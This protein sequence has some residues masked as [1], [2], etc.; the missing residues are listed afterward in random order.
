VNEDNS[1]R[2]FVKPNESEPQRELFE[3]PSAPVNQSGT[4]AKDPAALGNAGSGIEELALADGKI[5]KLNFGFGKNGEKFY[6]VGG[7]KY[8]TKQRVLRALHELQE[9]VAD[10]FAPTLLQPNRPR[11]RGKL[12]T[13]SRAQ[14]EEKRYIDPF[15]KKQTGAFFIIANWLIKA[16]CNQPKG[17]RL[18]WFAIAV[19]FQLTS[20][21]TLRDSGFCRQFRTGS[22]AAIIDLDLHLLADWLRADYSA[23]LDAFWSL[24][25]CGL[26]EIVGEAQDEK[27]RGPKTVRFLWHHWMEETGQNPVSPDDKQGKIH[28]ET[29]QNPVSPQ[30]LKTQRHL[31]ETRARESE[32]GDP[33]R[34]EQIFSAYPK[35][36][37]KPTALKAINQA[38][39]NYSVEFLLERTTA[40]AAARANCDDHPK[41]TPHPATWFRDERF[42]D[43]PSHWAAKQPAKKIAPFK[44]LT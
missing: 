21:V 24:V 30:G 25:G 1:Q 3:T 27:K 44:D 23:T 43:D 36:I 22:L 35:Q 19:Y 11:Y 40:Y 31:K 17:K 33:S 39:N 28:S 29:G 12:A 26:L 13:E 14:V 32:P 16:R 5:I 6:R 20:P 41:F 9:A 37:A 7:R 2:R 4:D 8:S 42:N 15:G 38:L 10:A 34:A 18:S